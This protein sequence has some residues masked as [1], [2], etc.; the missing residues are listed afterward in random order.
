MPDKVKRSDDAVWRRLDDTIVIIDTEGT[1]ILT[2]NSTAAFIWERCDG[3]KSE[4]EI[5]EQMSQEFDAN[6]IDLCK[7]VAGTIAR[8]KEKGL[9][10]II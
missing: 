10:Q 8:F 3:T 5:A 6:D 7:D 1:K 4:E 9:V 2:L